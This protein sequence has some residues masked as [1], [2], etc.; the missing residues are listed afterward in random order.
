MG[1]LEREVMDR[2][3]RDLGCVGPGCKESPFHRFRINAGMAWVANKEDTYRPSKPTVVRI[4]PGDVVLH[5]ARPFF[6][7]PPGWGD[8]TGWDSVIIGPE[9]VGQRRAIFA[10]DEAKTPNV[11]MSKEQRD[12]RELVRRWGGRYEEIR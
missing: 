5:R 3:L 6:G 2:R 1:E 4:Y 11:R 7:A 8:L 10:L 12:I 9:D